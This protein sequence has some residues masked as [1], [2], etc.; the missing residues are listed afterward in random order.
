[1]GVNFGTGGKEYDFPPVC[2]FPFIA[3]SPEIRTLLA[4]FLTSFR[5]VGIIVQTDKS[6]KYFI[7]RSDTKAMRNTKIIAKDSVSLDK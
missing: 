7:R 4:F 6:K 2:F 5:S 1:M 3:Q